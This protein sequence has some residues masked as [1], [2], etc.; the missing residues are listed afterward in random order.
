MQQGGGPMG[1]STITITTV[2]FNPAVDEKTF[3]KPAKK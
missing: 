3:E 1:A 2:T